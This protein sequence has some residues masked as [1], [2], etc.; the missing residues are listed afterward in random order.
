METNKYTNLSS[1]FSLFI[2]LLGL[3]LVCLL[4][5]N[6]KVLERTLYLP[7]LLGLENYRLKLVML[8][9]LVT[10]T[11]GAS[12]SNLIGVAAG[13]PWLAVHQ[14]LFVPCHMDLSVWQLTVWQLASLRMSRGRG[15]V[16]ISQ[17]ETTIFLQPSLSS[18]TPSLWP[19]FNFQTQVTRSSPHSRRGDYIWA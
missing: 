7:S 10:K 4:V 5:N 3:C 2:W 14:E 1:S 18:D 12:A 15:I 16:H 9:T 17:M 11:C 13:K 8:T 6:L 19:Y